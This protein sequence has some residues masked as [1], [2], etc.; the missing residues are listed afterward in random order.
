MPEYAAE[1]MHARPVASASI[2]LRHRTR[3][4]QA[5]HAAVRATRLARSDVAAPISPERTATDVRRPPAAAPRRPGFSA[6][7]PQSLGT[8]V[9]GGE[10]PAPI[11]KLDPELSAAPSG[12]G[13]AA[14]RNHA[15]DHLE[16]AERPCAGQEPV[17]TRQ[18]ASQSESEN[19]R[20]AAML[21]PVHDH[22]ERQ[23]R[24]AICGYPIH[25][26]PL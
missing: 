13:V 5:V 6:R 9:R 15:P 23:S 25:V 19:E 10:A 12:P 17:D 1:A 14:K 18:K 11:G 4:Q 26:R 7:A 22:H 8:R 21:K 2:A 3:S 16:H 20:W 24:H